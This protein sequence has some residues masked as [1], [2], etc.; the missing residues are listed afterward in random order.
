VANNSVPASGLANSIVTDAHRAAV[1][2]YTWPTTT[3]PADSAIG[4]TS[5][6]GLSVSLTLNETIDMNFATSVNILDGDYTVIV[7][8]N[9]VVLNEDSY[10][11][12][13]TADGRYRVRY[14]MNANKMCDVISVQIVN[15]D[16][17]EAQ[18]EAR[19]MSIRNYAQLILDNAGFR[20][21]D[22]YLMIAMLDYGSFAQ[23]NY[24]KANGGNISTMDL[25]NRY[26]TS[27]HRAFYQGYD[28]AN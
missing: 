15:K 2:S 18:Y 26:L 10:T 5:A 1:Q 22:K 21:I 13:K 7:K 24:A 20:E 28:W 25:A 14:C 4:S 6:S 19:A 11:I 8:K 23:I 9:G 27:D 17:S 16:K 3:A 12:T